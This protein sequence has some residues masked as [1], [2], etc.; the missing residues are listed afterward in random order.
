MEALVAGVSEGVASAKGAEQKP[1]HSGAAATRIVAAK[2]LI[3]RRMLIVIGTF[4]PNLLIR[5]I[6]YHN[7]KV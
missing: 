1:I 4:L 2:L 6:V 7:I 5:L 3:L